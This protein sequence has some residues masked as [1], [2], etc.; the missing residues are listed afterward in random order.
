MEFLGI[1]VPT[2]D[3]ESCITNAVG[4]VT[5]SSQCQS[6]HT[7]SHLIDDNYYVAIYTSL[8]PDDSDTHFRTVTLED[9]VAS[10]SIER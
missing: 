4:R 5:I 8:S 9:I 3:Q 10:L 6:G 1:K 2:A 7:E